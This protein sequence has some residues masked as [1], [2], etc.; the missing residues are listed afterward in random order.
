MWCL[1]LAGWS[2]WWCRLHDMAS[3]AAAHD[4]Q[5]NTCT[6][7]WS[8]GTSC[9]R[10]RCDSHWHG[11]LCWT[12]GLYQTCA[13]TDPKRQKVCSLSFIIQAP[14]WLTP[15]LTILT[16]PPDPWPMFNECI[17]LDTDT[18][19]LEK[20]IMLCVSLHTITPNH[21]PFCACSWKCMWLY[22]KH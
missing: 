18:E 13:S 14:C 19:T 11:S 8:A 20:A 10:S 9:W 21:L 2:P 6:W 3:P 7:T 12:P 16:F 15:S 4:H 1:C 22:W 17:S 5:G